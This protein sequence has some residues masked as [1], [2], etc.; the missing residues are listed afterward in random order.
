MSDR[1]RT[2]PKKS[3]VEIVNKAK[4]D[5]R[6]VTPLPS[7]NHL[8]SEGPDGYTSTPIEQ[9]AGIATASG[10]V[11]E[12]ITARSGS[13]PGPVTLGTGKV[14]I[15]ERVG[16]TYTY[17]ADGVEVDVKN[18]RMST[19]ALHKFVDIIQIDGQWRVFMADCGD[20]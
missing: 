5:I 16:N 11:T 1:R 19:I 2:G 17:D 4:R 18:G 9:E 13:Y 7:D 15:A 6:R 8:L 20:Y 14:I 10:F 3:L 12:A